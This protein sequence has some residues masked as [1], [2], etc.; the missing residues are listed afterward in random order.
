M[1]RN[2]W[3]NLPVKDLNRSRAFFREMGFAFNEKFGGNNEESACMEIGDKPDVIMLFAESTF[4]NFTRNDVTNTQKSSEVLL[5]VDVASRQEVDQMAH[6]A[7]KAGGV[8]FAAPEEIEGWMYGCGFA[9][10]DG[11]RWNVLYMD[12]DKMPDQ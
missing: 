7:E 2:L 12:M 4:R 6:R 9:D 10:V 11:H 8:V 5:S 3:L 1:T